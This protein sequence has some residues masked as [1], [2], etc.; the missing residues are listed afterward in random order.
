MNAPRNPSAPPDAGGVLLPCILALSLGL[1][2]LEFGSG[3]A[4][5]VVGATHSG[6]ILLVWLALATLPR[7][8]GPSEGRTA[9]FA[10]LAPALAVGLALDLERGA[11]PSELAGLTTCGLVLLA[12]WNEVGRT[13]VG[14]IWFVALPLSAGLAVALG[15]A[16]EASGQLAP[17]PALLDAL[18][19]TPLV[20][21]FD[22]TRAG[23]LREPALASELGA[24]AL[25][26]V[27]LGLAQ[28][29]RRTAA[30][31]SEGSAEYGAG[32]AEVGERSLFGAWP[33]LAL[34]P[35]LA[36]ETELR[37]YAAEFDVEGPV[38]V[39]EV[40]CG[41][42]G[43]TATELALGPGERRRV[44][45]VLPVRSPLGVDGLASL[46]RP[47]LRVLGPNA[48]A[49]A[50]SA[51]F[52]DWS[53]RQPAERFE[54]LPPLLRR[55]PRPTVA[56]RPAGL[57]ASVV[58]ALAALVCVLVALRRRPWLQLAT[59]L[60]GALLCFHLTRAGPSR[61]GPGIELWDGDLVAGAGLRIRARAG[62]LEAPFD[63]LA[64]RPEGLALRIECEGEEPL[65]V[66]GA[67]ELFGLRFAPPPLGAEGGD[68]RPPLAAVWTR[69][70]GGA[71]VA[72]GALASSG[73][74]AEALGDAA[75]GLDPSAP[76]Q[77]QLPGWLAGAPSTA[78]G[79]LVGRRVATEPGPE[80]WIRVRGLDAEVL[81][82][83]EG[84]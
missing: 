69:V 58:L 1:A 15:W 2:L 48:E 63:L 45:L 6:S 36:Q 28:R 82:G 70:P 20:W 83:P 34:A 41:A 57:G 55:G 47:T 30:V 26:C 17:Q 29:W 60:G 9:L 43:L 18:A 7:R 67:G 78:L 81:A 76:G 84:P 11:E 46:P 59:G 24:L 71:W 80:R 25:A 56:A 51:R 35:F 23:G 44:R 10:Y 75:L 77:G 52:A 33:W 38:T 61:A 14:W 37:G 16:G 3:G 12:L 19:A 68:L 40:D 50:G 72:R 27:A 42:D 32:N 53:A 5:V 4:L 74:L 66:R 13:G 49:A 62:E 65:R 39:L 54:R 21:A 73:S 31:G 79:E 22:W 64:V 8:R